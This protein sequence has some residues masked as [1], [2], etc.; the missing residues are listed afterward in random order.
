M[1]GLGCFVYD[2]PVVGLETWSC[3]A[4][5]CVFIVEDFVDDLGS[6]VFPYEF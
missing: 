3:D 5:A 2:G 6:F 4:P 1:R